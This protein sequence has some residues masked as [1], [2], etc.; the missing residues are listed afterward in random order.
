MWS[1]LT[2]AMDSF[3]KTSAAS[4]SPILATHLP[5]DRVPRAWSTP[6]ATPSVGEWQLKL[7]CLTLKQDLSSLLNQREIVI[8]T[9]NPS[10]S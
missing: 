3:A 4:K 10:L 2:A 7:V 8:K 5:V 1:T 6:P 9:N